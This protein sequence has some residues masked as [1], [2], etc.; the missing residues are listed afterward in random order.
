MATPTPL[1]NTPQKPLAALSSPA[2]RS[3]PP[4][5]FDSP[6]VLNMLSEGGV[7]MGISMSGL[8]M[9]SLGLSASQLGRADEDERRRRLQSIL[10]AL[11]ER[12]RRV[13]EEGIIALCNKEGVECERAVEADGS[14][15]LTLI[16]GNEAICDVQLLNGDV[17]SVKLELASDE[18]SVF[19]ESGSN[20]L[21]KSLT[22]QP[23]TN[24]INLNL[25]N[26]GHNLDKLLRMDKLSAD[27]GGVQCYKA[28]FKVYESLKRLFEHE[29]KMALALMDA[30]A[31]NAT[32]RAEREVMCKK[33]G[34]PR[35][36]AG[37]CLGLSL[38][39]WMDRRH[40]ATK[41]PQSG[42]SAKAKGKATVDSG[43]AGAYPEDADP[44]THKIYSLT[45][46]CEASPSS[47]YTPIRIPSSWISDA[48]EKPPDATDADINN[49]LVTTPQTDWLDPKPTFLDTTAMPADH[50]AMNLD[51]APGRLPNVRF[52]AKF[53]P[54]LV[55]PLQEYVR[56]FQQVGLEWNQHELRHTSFVG[57]ALRPGE[58]DPWMTSGAGGPTIEVRSEDKVLVV[59]KERKE[60]YQ[61]HSNAL[62]V[63]K[64]EYSR[65][66]ESLP[67]QHPKQLIDILPT[68]R[69]YAFTTS[70]LQNTFNAHA[71]S[72]AP[73][74]STG[75][76]SFSPTTTPI[77]LDVTLSYTPP[78]PNLTLHVPHPLSPSQPQD[79]TMPKSTTDLLAHLLST[80]SASSHH[81]P[82]KVDFTVGPNAE[83][84]IGAQNVVEV[85]KASEGADVDMEGL[86]RVKRVARALDVCGDLGV[87]AEWCRREVGR[88]E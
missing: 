8:G 55:V 33:S 73:Q 67:F 71:A 4:I 28:V 77:P 16:I 13:S 11:N 41:K 34:R 58:M 23:G 84:G 86:E 50:D 52:V 25:E 51:N 59:D 32:F 42:A 10:S 69:T 18:E 36:N 12:S 68:L 15:V 38:E 43:T 30:D 1:T 35:I 6:A 2:P 63:P 83:I 72:T 56:I 47:M 49:L 40:L 76:S 80:S 21:Y 9:S 17:K 70:L 79:S 14:V 29:K 61:T 20:I 46:E 22:T 19:K 48:I 27:N 44:E 62:M 45:V 24:R 81:P 85:G 3:V 74:P 37:Y 54:P 66:L 82:L 78:A 7:G 39:Y 57:L 31:P 64:L 60:T 65:T 75:T 87:W 88:E 5:N 53:N 26:F